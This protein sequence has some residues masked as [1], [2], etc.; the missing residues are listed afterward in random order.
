MAVNVQYTERTYRRTDG[1]TNGGRL[2]RSGDTKVGG[3]GPIRLHCVY[4]ANDC[5]PRK[6]DNGQCMVSFECILD[7]LVAAVWLDR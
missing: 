6:G 2:V 3:G 7:M 5:W 1:R 4:C